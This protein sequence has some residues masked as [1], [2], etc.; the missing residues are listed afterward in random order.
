MAPLFPPPWEV[1]LP[2]VPCL[3]L[4]PASSPFGLTGRPRPVS[5]PAPWAPRVALAAAPASAPRGVP[6]SGAEQR[7]RPTGGS[8][9]RASALPGRLELRVG[10]KGSSLTKPPGAF[11]LVAKMPGSS[12]QGPPVRL[13]E[14][15]RADGNLA[16]CT[17]GSCGPSV[18]AELHRASESPLC[19]AA[20]SPCVWNLKSYRCPEL[21]TGKRQ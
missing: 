17:E 11:G 13:A 8:C 10:N 1:P 7:A 9:S 19:N 21:L 18:E 16:P 12:G 2:G 15:R 4:S 5:P 3:F 6:S 14:A 20:A